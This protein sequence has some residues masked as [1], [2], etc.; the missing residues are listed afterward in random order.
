VPVSD[1]GAVDQPRLRGRYGLGVSNCR[2][3]TAVVNAVA[4]AERLGAEAAF[5]AEDI[6][7]RDTFALLSVAASR[8]DTIRLFT[9][10]VNPYTRA[11]IS[12]AMGA[13]TVHELS[14]GRAGIGLGTSSPA[15]ITGQL[16]LPHERPVRAMREATEVLR[17]LW[18][19]TPVSYQGDLIHL[20]GAHLDIRVPSGK[21]PVY[22]AAMGQQMLR[23]AGRLADG[24]LLNVGASVD[25]VRWAVD[26]IR[27]AAEAVDRDP[28]DITVAA[29]HT[30]YLD[31]DEEVAVKKARRW[32]AGTLSIPG[33]G[34]L[35]LEHSGCSSEILGPI[36]ELVSAYPHGG[37]PDR[38]AEYVSEEVARRLTLIGSAGEV[39]KR[40]AEYR[41]AGVDLPVLA[42][43]TLRAVAAYEGLPSPG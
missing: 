8:T 20:E 17:L 7:C 32:L 29:W 27:S 6:G 42:I 5:V 41:A 18:S 1:P 11:P 9:G 24:V 34:E 2:P 12:L 38:A 26:Q 33:Q 35:L 40:V 25:Y 28:Q 22:F 4:E 13:A 43:S 21:I 36:R 10:V 23:L 31:D 15:L 39:V 19:N 16:G 14:G 3:G 30:A 37:D